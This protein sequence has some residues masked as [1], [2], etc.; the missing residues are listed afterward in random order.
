LRKRKNL[1]FWRIENGLKQVDVYKKLKI[2]SGYYSNLE[3]GRVNPSFPLL[4]KFKEIFEVD[5]IIELFKL[6]EGVG[7]YGNND[8]SGD[9]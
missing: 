2:S 3:K 4:V 5:D 6:S 9:I 8:T 1:I 7:N